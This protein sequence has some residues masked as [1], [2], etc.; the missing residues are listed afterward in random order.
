MHNPIQHHLLKRRRKKKRRKWR[1]ANIL[2]ISRHGGCLYH[3]YTCCCVHEL[4]VVLRP[5]SEHARGYNRAARR[6]LSRL[7]TATKLSNF[8]FQ[9]KAIFNTMDINEPKHRRAL[10]AAVVVALLMY[11]SLP[12]WRNRETEALAQAYF[13][14]Q[15]P[16][17][18]RSRYA[19]N[20]CFALLSTLV[21]TC[22]SMSAFGRR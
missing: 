2:Q 15:R 18:L 5:L 7:S 11:C 8:F 9:F 12:E 10:G 22:P 21:S 19:S 16:A 6:T 3:T 20:T 17:I 13:E 4:T 1:E 14:Q